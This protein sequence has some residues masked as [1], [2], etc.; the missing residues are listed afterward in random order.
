MSLCQHFITILL[1][2]KSSLAGNLEI[3][4]GSDNYR[5]KKKRKKKDGSIIIITDG[6]EEKGNEYLV[7]G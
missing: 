2:F 6:P 3:S 7:T 4:L 5:K 1:Q